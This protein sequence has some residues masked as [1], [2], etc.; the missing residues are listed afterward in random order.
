VSVV[1]PCYNYG[2]YLP[3]AVA[4][5]LEQPGVVVDVTIVDDAS[6]D[7]SQA[8]ALEL[9]AADRRAPAV[10]H[11]TNMGHVATY[12]DGLG[13]AEATYVVLLS[14]DDLLAPGSLQRSTALMEAR[15]DVGLVYGYAPDFAD[16]PPPH[17]DE[18]RNWSVWSGQAWLRRICRRG[19]NIIVNPEAML[20]TSV[21]TELGGYDA[22]L[23]HSADMDL[24]MR[25]ARLADVGRVNGPYQAY[26]RVHGGNMHMTD[27]AGLLTDMKERLR[28]FDQFFT[29]ADDKLRNSDRMLAS[30]RR[31][32][33]YEA[34]RVARM[35]GGDPVGA[36]ALAHFA[37][38][39]YPR[40]TSTALWIAYRSSGH[41]PLRDARRAAAAFEYDLRWR[42]RWRRT[43]RFGT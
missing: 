30:A 3:A 25:A 26:Y 27:Y 40:I 24:W 31:A 13:R 8:V 17:R 36:A 29:N 43:R 39:C 41:G 7:G 22:A 28:T 33:A 6:T 12:N 10:I 15:P 11:E 16:A 2:R 1:I 9:A 20:R 42:Y 32:I 37:I 18:V 35:T 14:A 4:S 5:A 21:L 19:T 38:E 34:V 23:P